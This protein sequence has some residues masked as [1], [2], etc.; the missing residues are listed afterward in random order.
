MKPKAFK[1]ESTRLLL[2]KFLSDKFNECSRHFPR[3]APQWKIGVHR[4]TCCIPVSE[5]MHKR[6]AIQFLLA[7]PKGCRGDSETAR[8]A[9]DGTCDRVSRDMTRQLIPAT[10]M[11]C[12]V[13]W[14]TAT[15]SWR[16]K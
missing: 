5:N 16:P 6:S 1:G 2:S 11:R 9:R 10:S 7:T 13:P 3:R 15:R 8:R 14:S 12:M 4:K